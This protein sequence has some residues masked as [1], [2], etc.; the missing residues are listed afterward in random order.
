MTARAVVGK[1][2][3]RILRALGRYHLLTAEQIT[4]LL[5]RPGSLRDVQK[6]LA[7]LVAAGYLIPKRGYSRSTG[8]PPAI[9]ALGRRGRDYAAAAGLELRHRFRPGEERG[10]LFYAHTLALND[11]L[12]A[13]ERLAARTGRFWIETMLHD[14]LLQQT[15]LRVTLHGGRPARVVPDAWLDLRFSRPGE[16]P[17][18]ECYV[19]EL[20]RGTE[21]Q[22]D[23][24]AKVEALIAAT[25]GPYQD[26]FGTDLMTVAVVAAPERNPD[27]RRR[28]L[29]EWIEWE[30]E[31]LDRPDQ[32]DLFYVAS[33]DSAAVS[34]EDL[35]CSASWYAPFSGV[36]APLWEIPGEE[37]V[38]G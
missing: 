10:Y 12:I 26:A 33:L 31:R 38:G 24:R 34:P 37:E 35:F 23:F 4:R 19:V 21:R 1:A 16:R 27:Q 20:D 18:R 11:V 14:Q 32:A 28:Q 15:P 25:E 30:L 22:R 8:R 29:L 5:Y 7:K 13:A 3:D 9:Y 36:P 2:E 17:I 6:R